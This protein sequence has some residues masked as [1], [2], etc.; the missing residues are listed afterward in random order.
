MAKLE[1][2]ISRIFD[3]LEGVIHNSALLE[4]MAAARRRL[5]KLIEGSL[6]AD[7]VSKERLLGLIGGGIVILKQWDDPLHFV[8]DELKEAVEKM[9]TVGVADE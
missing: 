8:I 4:D 5:D 6:F 7:P 3:I 1:Q 2:E 9:E